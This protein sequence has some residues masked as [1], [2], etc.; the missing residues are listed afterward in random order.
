MALLCNTAASA[1][2]FSVFVVVFVRYTKIYEYINPSIWHH[3]HDNLAERSKAL[4][5]GAS[6]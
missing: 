6:S 4:A 1:D 5:S 3:K 2:N